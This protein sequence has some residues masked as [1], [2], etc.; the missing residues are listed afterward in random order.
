MAHIHSP[1][2]LAFIYIPIDFRLK[3]QTEVIVCSSIHI[4]HVYH[5]RFQRFH[6]NWNCKGVKL[7]SSCVVPGSRSVH[8]FGC[9]FCKLQRG[10]EEV[11][12]FRLPGP[13]GLST[14]PGW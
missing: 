14:M 3:Q 2:F 10:A 8:T 6:T 7:P 12:H 5:T 11:D 9:W 1:I 4:T 13:P